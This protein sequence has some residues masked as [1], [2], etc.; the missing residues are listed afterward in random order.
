MV[1]IWPSV[2]LRRI[3]GRKK[4]SARRLGEQRHDQQRRQ[5]GANPSP[6]GSGSFTVSGVATAGLSPTSIYPSIVVPGPTI[7]C[8]LLIFVVFG[9]R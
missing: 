3:L 2:F 6:S 8:C 1:A 5:P 4:A 9:T 7:E